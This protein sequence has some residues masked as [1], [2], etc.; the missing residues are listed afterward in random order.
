MMRFS[1]GVSAWLL[2][3]LLLAGCGRAAMEGK[4]GAASPSALHG[5]GSPDSEMAAPAPAPDVNE[6]SNSTAGDS[7]MAP[8]S[9]A[10]PSGAARGAAEPSAREMLDIEAH[11]SLFVAGVS[12]A[13]QQLRQQAA[14]RSATITSDVS[15]DASGAHVAKL[16]IRVPIGTNDAFMADLERLGDI[17]GRQIVAKDVGREYHDSEIVLHNLERTLARYEEILKKAQ[18]VEEILKI[19]AELSRIR[20]EIDRVKGALRYLGDRTSR[21]TVYVLLR[22]RPKFI[23]QDPR[24]VAKFYPGVRVVSLIELGGEQKT[25]PALGAGIAVGAGRHLYIE[26]DALKRVNSGSSGLD[27]VLATIGGDAY[28]DFLGGGKRRFLNP[29][30]GLRAGYARTSAR[31]HFAIGGTVGVE[32]WKTN[33]ATIDCDIRALGLLGEGHSEFALQPTLGANVAF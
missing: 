11:F 4:G 24:P 17:T 1:V 31:N 23:A 3:G 25:Q 2:C 30:L 13:R 27:A 15:E 12:V 22:E 33:F 7:A 32:L 29:Y 10:P 5:G 19:E 21:A 16:T 6:G 8:T 28:S 26:L 20:G 9:P 14:A 18:S